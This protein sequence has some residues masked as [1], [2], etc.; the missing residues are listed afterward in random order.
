MPLTDG[1]I[2]LDGQDVTTMSGDALH[3]LRRQA[4]IIFQN[5]FASLNPRMTIGNIIA[6]PLRVHGI[7]REV[8]PQGA[9]S[10]ATG[11]GRH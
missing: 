11:P 6:D 8:G 10:G 9:G 7:G 1:R 5:P 4:Q 2:L 3:Q